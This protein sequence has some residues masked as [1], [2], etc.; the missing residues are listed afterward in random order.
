MGQMLSTWPFDSAQYVVTL[1]AV[2]LLRVGTVSIAQSHQVLHA[3]AGPIPELSG[4]KSLVFSLS[5]PPSE[6]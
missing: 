2:V 5:S 4:L 1:L 6:M 3:G